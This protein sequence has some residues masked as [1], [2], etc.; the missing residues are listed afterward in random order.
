MLSDGAGAAVLARVRRNRIKGSRFEVDWIELKSFANRFMAV[1]VRR[2]RRRTAAASASWLDYPS[3][4]RAADDGAIN[5]RQDMRML[6]RRSQDSPCGG[7]V[8]SR[9]A[10]PVESRPDRL[11]RRRTIHRRSSSRRRTERHA[12]ADSRSRAN[13]GSP[14]CGRRATSGRLRFSC[15]WRSCCSSGEARTGPDASSA[16]SRRA[17]DSCSATCC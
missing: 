2:P 9:R 17:G 3:Y 4:H 10:R 13:A 5:L 14:I 15:C 8:A 6:G 11:A 1:H 16:S 7:A 12:G